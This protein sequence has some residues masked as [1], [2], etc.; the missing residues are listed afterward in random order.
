MTPMLVAETVTDANT[1]K[2]KARNRH[3]HHHQRHRDAKAC[4]DCPFEPFAGS[5]FYG[6]G[7]E[8]LAKFAKLCESLGYTPQGIEDIHNDINRLYA[9]FLKRLNVDFLKR[10]NEE[11]RVIAQNTVC[12]PV[13]QYDPIHR[14]PEDTYR[15]DFG[16]ESDNE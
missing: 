5:T 10:V 15:E 1:Q 13:S 6:Y 7:L 11:V 3:E 9:D 4:N 2:R 12:R 14:N 16:K 8:Q